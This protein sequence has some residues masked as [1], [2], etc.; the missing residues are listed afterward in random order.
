[1]GGTTTAFDTMPA[2]VQKRKSPISLE[3]RIIELTLENGRLR[4]EIDYC[5]SLVKEVLHPVM[6]LVQCHVH[7]LESGVRKFNEKI[8][9]SNW[10]ND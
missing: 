2:E 10:Q 6:A 3:D 4:L 8:E 7:G 1:M 5:K 9:R